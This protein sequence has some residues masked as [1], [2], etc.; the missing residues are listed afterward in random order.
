MKML[1]TYNENEWESF[2]NSKGL[3]LR[4]QATLTRIK[5]E[6]HNDKQLSQKN[7]KAGAPTHLYSASADRFSLMLAGLSVFILAAVFFILSLPRPD[8]KSLRMTETQTSAPQVEQSLPMEGNDYEARFLE[9][10]IQEEKAALAAEERISA[11]PDDHPHIATASEQKA[12][13]GV[14]PLLNTSGSQF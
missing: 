1:P 12:S 5:I 9:K 11:N 8:A 2:I 4:P 3:T 10:K 7:P 13:L 14:N 6:F